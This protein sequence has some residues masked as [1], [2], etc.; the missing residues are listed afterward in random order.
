[1]KTIT[2]LPAVLF[3][4]FLLVSGGTLG[5]SQISD[6]VKSIE[7]APIPEEGREYYLRHGIWHE[8]WKFDT[9]NYAR[10]TLVPINAKVRVEKLLGEKMSIRVIADSQLIWIYNRTKYSRQSMYEIARRMLSEKETPLRGCSD[11]TAAAIRSG[12][13]KLGMSKVEVIMARGW[14]PAHKTPSLDL[15]TWVY[16]PSRYVQQTIVFKDGKLA[17]GR[18][19]N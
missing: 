1:M 13:M 17:E 5:A 16:W 14:P 2:R 4:A 7:N 15:D 10:G 3:A 12:V 6:Y 11:E 19:V 8:M 18:D 9:T